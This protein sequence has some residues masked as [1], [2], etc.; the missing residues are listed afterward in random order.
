MKS[1]LIL[2]YGHVAA[3]A[4]RELV[5]AKV[6]SDILRNIFQYFSTKVGASADCLRGGRHAGG[7]GTSPPELRVLTPFTFVVQV[8][9]IKVETTVQ[10]V[11]VKCELCLF[12]FLWAGLVVSFRGRSQGD[13][14]WG[15]PVPVPRDSIWEHGARTGPHSPRSSFSSYRHS[16]GP[17]ASVPAWMLGGGWTED[18]RRASERLAGWPTGWGSAPRCSRRPPPAEPH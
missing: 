16:R 11:G 9:G 17:G 5:L 12:S 7:A 6:E 18:G 3:R 13:A 2:C 10:C 8:L 15:S 14:P 4:P 1:T